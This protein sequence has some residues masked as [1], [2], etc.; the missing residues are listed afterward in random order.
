MQV[1]AEELARITG[2]VSSHG[3]TYVSIPHRDI[4]AS[5]L[6]AEQM[7]HRAG[8][9]GADPS[10]PE[11]RRRRRGVQ[12][13]QSANAASKGIRGDGAKRSCDA[14]HI[15][16]VT[17]SKRRRLEVP[18]VCRSVTPSALSLLIDIDD[19]EL[20]DPSNSHTTT[21]QDVA[22]PA[23]PLPDKHGDIHFAEMATTLRCINDTQDLIRFGTNNR[24][25]ALRE[26]ELYCIKQRSEVS[27]LTL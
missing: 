4:L 1:Q 8:L 27:R 9:Q 15:D 6:S 7:A 3:E 20:D 14:E 17:L 21:S 19:Q 5:Q 26:R 22:E 23:S 11:P 2:A 16:D 24:D 10:T 13:E 12:G 25:Q 18:M